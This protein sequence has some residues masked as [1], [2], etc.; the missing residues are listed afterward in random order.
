MHYGAI[1]FDITSSFPEISSIAAALAELKNVS[2][3]TGFAPYDASTAFTKEEHEAMHSRLPGSEL[4]FPHSFIQQPVH[5]VAGD[6]ESEIV[7]RI[8]GGFAWDSALRFLL[9]G[10]VDGI[11]AEIHNTCNQT[12]SYYLKGH[13]AFYI[14]EGAKHESQYEHME[15]V[16]DL[17]PN[18]HPKASNTPGHCQYT[19]VSTS[20][21]AQI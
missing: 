15:V 14:G 12:N 21:L 4:E 11:V 9:P 3:L 10:N 5:K 2:L 17:S 20:G 6:Y 16:R 1:N 7:A 18:I 8:G 13:D 19:I